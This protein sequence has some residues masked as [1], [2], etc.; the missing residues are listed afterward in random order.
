MSRNEIT[1]DKL[2][3]KVGNTEA[4]N[5]GYDRIFSNKEKKPPF[6][7]GTIPSYYPPQKGTHSILEGEENMGKNVECNHWVPG[8]DASPND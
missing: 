3:S 6:T 8:W 2:Q 5:E 4:F 7:G 1:G